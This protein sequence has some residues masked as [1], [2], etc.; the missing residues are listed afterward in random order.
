MGPVVASIDNEPRNCNMFRAL[1]PGALIVCL[2]TPHSDNSPPLE[3]GIPVV[4]DYRF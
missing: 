1:F 3:A 2:D 4:H